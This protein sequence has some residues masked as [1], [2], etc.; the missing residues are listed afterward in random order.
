[1]STVM[2]PQTGEVLQDE[3]GREIPDPNPVEVPLGMKRPETL[4]E[5]VQR[6]VRTSVSAYA[7]MHGEET[8]AE[9]DD[10]EVD[11]D[12][13]PSTPYEV[14]FD[15]VLGRDITP[16]DFMDA[17]KREWLRDQYMLAERNAIRS[18]ARQEA[19]DEAHKA[20]KANS[21]KMRSPTG[22]SPSTPP[23]AT[24]ASPAAK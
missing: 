10:L 20:A 7:E 1:M 22:T 4:A 13:D 24:P 5:Q 21:R 12:F 23:E 2:D 6:L 17:Q 16:A 3:H 8:F 11:D 19:I 15:P 18:E 9:A 14:D